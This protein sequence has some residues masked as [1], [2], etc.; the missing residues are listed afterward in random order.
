MKNYLLLMMGVSMV[1]CSTGLQEN[2]F[3]N[4]HG[5]YIVSQSLVNDRFTASQPHV[6]GTFACGS[7][8]TSEQMAELRQ[9]GAVHSWYH[10]CTPVQDYQAGAYQ[11]LADQPVATLYKGPLEAAIIGGSIGAGLALS[12]DTVTNSNRASAGAISGSSATATSGRGHHRR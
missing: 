7:R 4:E 12:G 10:A 9:D 6:S 5:V 11:T 8:Y 2:A 1:A 3:R